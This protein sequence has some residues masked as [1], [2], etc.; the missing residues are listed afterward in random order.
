MANTENKHSFAQA[1]LQFRE[2]NANFGS[3]DT[4]IY[5]HVSFKS[6]EWD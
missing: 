6:T 2:D 5:G 1:L 4:P 3:T